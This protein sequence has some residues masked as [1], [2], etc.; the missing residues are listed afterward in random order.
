MRI[1]NPEITQANLKSQWIVNEN[2]LGR[3]SQIRFF[4]HFGSG[5]RI[6]QR[7]KK[8][9]GSRIRIR[10]TDQ[11]Q[12]PND[13]WET[14]PSQRRV[15][16]AAWPAAPPPCPPGF[17]TSPTSSCSQRRRSP[18]TRPAC[19]PGPGRSRWNR[20]R[21]PLWVPCSWSSG[22]SRPVG[23]GEKRQVG[24]TGYSVADPLIPDPG[25]GFFH[26]GSRI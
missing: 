14:G 2:N 12:L 3:S 26:P 20:C 10:N 24:A 7:W 18:R 17:G 16:R 23:K 11:Y 22:A 9:P 5:S 15:A 25:K 21:S 19:R 6:A 1:R 13:T 8:A 4:S